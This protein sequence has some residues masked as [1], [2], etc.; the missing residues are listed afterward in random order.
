MPDI[1]TVKHT[2]DAI[3]NK[4]KKISALIKLYSQNI[5]TGN[6]STLSTDDIS[7]MFE[8]Y[9]RIFLNGWF[10]DNF[11]GKL[12]FSL[13]RRMT[14]SAGITFCP[15]NASKIRPE[16]LT[17]EIRI[18]VDFFFKY[19]LI[20]GSKTVC[21]IKT[22]DGLEA[23]Q[24]VFEHELCHVIEF[25]HFKRSN[26]RGKRFK[27]IAGS[28]FGHT[29]SWHK[30]PTNKQI[31]NQLLGLKIG[32]T[33]RFDHEGRSLTGTISNINKRATVLV[34]DKRGFLIDKQGNRYLRYYLPLTLLQK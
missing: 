24:I 5:N 6:I 1:L 13:S 27:T 25:I 20:K 31:A 16:E 2:E 18:G 23:L 33:V 7:L 26:C 9:D 3:Q 12:K 34:R 14:K 4:R 30:L 22:R 15:R 10:S 11:R 8:L 21:G 19:D 32:D 28:L 29:E 17:L